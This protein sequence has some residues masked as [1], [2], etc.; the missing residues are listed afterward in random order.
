L[1]W[2]ADADDATCFGLHVGLGESCLVV[3]G[4]LEISRFT[5]DGRRVWAFGG[6]DIF[7]GELVVAERSIVV[8][9]FEGQRYSI[10]LE[11]G[12]GSMLRAG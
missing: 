8:T 6:K 5:L 2:Q 12:A 11:S 10:D 7:S 9:D 3:H 4:E 1:L